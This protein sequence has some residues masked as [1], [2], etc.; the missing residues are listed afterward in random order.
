MGMRRLRISVVA[1]LALAV[2]GSGL[3]AAPAQAQ[4]P[5]VPYFGKNQIRFFNFDWKVYQTEHFEIFYYGS[6]APHLERIA[7][8]A[9]NA[10]L[11]I[12]SELKHEIPDRIPLI[13]FKTQSEFQTNNVFVGVP[14]GVL[15]FTE[16]ERRRMVVPIDEPPDQLYRLITHELTHAFEFDMIPRGIMGSAVP[17]WMDEGLSDYMAGYWNILDLMQVRDAAISDNVPR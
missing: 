12:S 16:P 3:L 1:A 14:E 2:V 9:E 8:Y 5:F 11:H 7:G 17:L 4:T 10:Y 13:L 15:A 6:I